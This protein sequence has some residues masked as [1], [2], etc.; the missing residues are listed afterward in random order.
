MRID[1]LF[2][3]SATTSL[4]RN[5]FY[6]SVRQFSST[7]TTEIMG[8]RRGK[9]TKHK[10]ALKKLIMLGYACEKSFHPGGKI[11]DVGFP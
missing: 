3:K 10:N 2:S 9:A 11:A 6:L 4:K 8:V 7:L 1:E 5:K